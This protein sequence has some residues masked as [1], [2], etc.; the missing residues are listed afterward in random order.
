M[1]NILTLLQK[2]KYS[3]KS[4][5]KI[6]ITQSSRKVFFGIW[7]KKIAKNAWKCKITTVLVTV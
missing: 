6:H 4:E 5:N 7:P 2:N 3:S 1:H